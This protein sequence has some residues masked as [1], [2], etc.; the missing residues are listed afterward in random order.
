MQVKRCFGHSGERECLMF[1]CNCPSECYECYIKYYQLKK[2][3]YPV[4][5]ID[6]INS[7][8]KENKL[9]FRDTFQMK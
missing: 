8:M 6:I 3:D 7:Y 1:M 4:R 2:Q 5:V 9:T